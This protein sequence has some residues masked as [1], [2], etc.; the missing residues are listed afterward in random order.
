MEPLRTR[1][2]AI[3]VLGGPKHGSPIRA[4]RFETP[5]PPLH[6]DVEEGELGALPM[7]EHPVG[8]DITDDAPAGT[9]VTGSDW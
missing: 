8:K 5:I 1:L 6:P 3:E 7:H 2:E 9:H 4:Q